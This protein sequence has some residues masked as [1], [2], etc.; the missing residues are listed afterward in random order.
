MKC[1]KCNKTLKIKD[2]V[3]VNKRIKNWSIGDMSY[4]VYE[5]GQFIDIEDCNG[6]KRGNKG[7]LGVQRIKKEYLTCFDCGEF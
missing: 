5:S 2:A 6:G 4:I 1:P 7:R 3:V